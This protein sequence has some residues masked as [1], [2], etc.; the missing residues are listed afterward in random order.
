MALSTYLPMADK[1]ADEQS[2][3]S[4]GL[5]A[6]M[7]HGSLD[8]VVP[9]ALGLMSRDKLVTL[10]LDVEWHSYPMPHS[11]SAQE[12]GDIAG[13]LADRFAAE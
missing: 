13:W 9:Q 12:I 11:V 1:S 2:E 8:P 7:G 4:K 3:A 5:P 6:F 10:G